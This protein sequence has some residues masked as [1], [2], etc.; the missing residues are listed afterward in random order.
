MKRRMMRFVA[1]LF[2][3][4]LTAALCLAP[5]ALAEEPA[6]YLYDRE[7][8]E[9]TPLDGLTS[10]DSATGIIDIGFSGGEPGTVYR[11]TFSGEGENG[12]PFEVYYV[13]TAA[14]EGED[15]E[16]DAQFQEIPLTDKPGVYG[17]L[18]ARLEWDGQSVDYSFDVNIPEGEIDSWAGYGVIANPHI[19]MKPSVSVVMGDTGGPSSVSGDLTLMDP[20]DGAVISAPA[21][22]FGLEYEIWITG[23]G[24]EMLTSRILDAETGEEIVA[25][26]HGEV[27]MYTDPDGKPIPLEY[28]LSFMV[29]EGVLTS[30]RDYVLEVTMGESTVSARFTF[31]LEG[32]Q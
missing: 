29:E 24:G 18:N 7:K 6:L 15:G 21:G 30:G 2:A 5:A 13:F 23:K 3:L 25:D 1:A 14:Q 26:D 17:P 27:E 31:L 16:Q 9:R 19:S 8:E 22:E 32:G 12:Q 28:S 20:G 10:V 4:T 11:M